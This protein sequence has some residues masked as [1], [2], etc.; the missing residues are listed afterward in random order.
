MTMPTTVDASYTAIVRAADGVRL[1]ISA[2]SE[3]ARRRALVEYIRERYEHT[4][5]DDQAQVIARLLEA[6][7]EDDAIT[8]YFAMVGQRWDEES[9]ELG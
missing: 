2:E 1:S 4:L 3:E 9:V 5:W 7:R 6:G 8:S